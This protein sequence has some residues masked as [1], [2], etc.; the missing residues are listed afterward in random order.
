[1]G[2]GRERG[3]GDSVLHVAVANGNDG[4]AEMLIEQN[5]DIESKSDCDGMT[6]LMRTAEMDQPKCARMLLDHGANLAALD[7][8]GHT[9]L[10]WAFLHSA[11]VAQILL[12]RGGKPCAWNC[13][14]CANALR[15]R[16][17]AAATGSGKSGGGSDK[18]GGGSGGGSGNHHGGGG[19]GGGGSALGEPPAKHQGI[20][21]TK[22][23]KPPVQPPIDRSKLDKIELDRL[24]I[25]QV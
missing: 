5:A 1:M 14:K 24:D 10:H 15:R 4:T 12:E 8:K 6:P 20:A 21:A 18:S 23:P 11:D 19:G 13:L 7:K 22:A 25:A 2:R 9:A 3:R 17:E 16:E